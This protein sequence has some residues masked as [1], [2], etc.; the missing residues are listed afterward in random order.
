MEIPNWDFFN[1]MV[2]FEE[3]A[4]KNEIVLFPWQRKFAMRLIEQPPT[5]GK[6]YLLEVLHEYDNKVGL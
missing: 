6:S 3:W 5:S 4:D 2:Q 1:K